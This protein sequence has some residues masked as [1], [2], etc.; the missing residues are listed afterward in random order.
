MEP[1]NKPVPFFSIVVPIYNTQEYIK[2]CLDSVL[3][4]TFSNYECILIDDGST[5]NSY[6][7]C[8]EYASLN[9]KIKLIQ[10]NNM[11]V[12]IARNTGIIAAK[13][14]FIVFLDSDDK[15]F[16]QTSLHDLYVLINNNYSNII[17]H[18]TNYIFSKDKVLFSK[19]TIDDINIV[20]SAERFTKYCFHPNSKILLAAWSF[21]INRLFLL[22][23]NL[24]Y[25]ENIIHEDNHFIPR[26]LC[27][28]DNITINNKTFYCYRRNRIGAITYS[29][30]K[31]R[32]LDIMTI[33]DDLLVLHNN[34]TVLLN[35]KIYSYF[36]RNLWLDLYKA[37]L[38]FNDKET[39][40]K[41]YD[42]LKKT[43]YCIILNFKPKHLFLY[44]VIKIFGL[45]NSVYFRKIIH[46]II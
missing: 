13:G 10:Q 6:T 1:E 37:L 30:S 31:K 7:I 22:K 24:F 2:E 3:Q 17:F 11:G 36:C 28:T 20:I 26:L 40:N 21:T 35:K 38:T 33:M 15:I 45:K 25:K 42:Y 4:Q 14:D 23:N 18:S 39:E 41:I 29:I 32:L 5:D 44:L 46:K 12:S 34:E 16:N 27:L 19:N 9:S 43:S 8:N